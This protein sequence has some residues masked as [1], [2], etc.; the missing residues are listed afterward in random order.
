MG[1]KT[2]KPRG[3]NGGRPPKL[4]PIE[5]RELGRHA[6]L[7]RRGSPFPSYALPNG[8]DGGWP[9]SKAAQ[10][11]LD[12]RA[13]MLADRE[14]GVIVPEHVQRAADAAQKWGS[15]LRRSDLRLRQP[16]P[17]QDDDPQDQPD[18]IT[19]PDVERIPQGS[20]HWVLES[21]QWAKDQY[22]ETIKGDLVRGAESEY[23][24]MI[25]QWNKMANEG[26]E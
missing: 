6:Y 17:P 5:R 18:E 4:S 20:R 2:N 13:L 9:L 21:I 14:S 25:E 26:N 24:Q 10:K 8:A 23:R 15:K 3:R 12:T 1:L 22:G 16:E 11:I 7:L 19:P